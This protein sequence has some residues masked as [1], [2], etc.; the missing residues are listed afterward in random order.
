MQAT[1][2]HGF[3]DLLKPIGNSI[4][5]T[6]KQ[7]AEQQPALQILH[8]AAVIKRKE[9]IRL[10]LQVVIIF[11]LVDRTVFPA[12]GGPYTERTVAL[13]IK[14]S[15]TSSKRLIFEIG[16]SD[17]GLGLRF[18]SD[19]LVA[20]IASGS[21]RNTITLSNFASN[22]N[23]LSGQWNHVAVVY[24]VST[25]TLYL[26]GVSVASNNSLSF[27]SIGSS[28]NA[29]RLGDVSGTNSG[30]VFNDGSYS[31]YLGSMDNLYI[32]RSALGVADIN[33]LRTNTFAQ[34]VATTLAAPTPPAAPT[35]LTTEVLSTNAIKLTWNDNS[36]NETGFE[37]WRS[38][39]D[40][41]NNRKIATVDA[42]NTSSLTFTDST[43]F[44]N[45]TYYYKVRAIGL[46]GASAYTAEASGKTLN[47]KP[48]ITK[49]LDFTM[50]YGTTYVLPV[51]AVDVDG[52]VLTFS[53][54][55]LP[56]FATIENASNGNINIS[57]SPGYNQERC[58]YYICVC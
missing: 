26:N 8:S 30:V 31:D 42:G 53:T 58:I 48:V 21:T 36:S 14:P 28:S 34:S 54:F 43:L 9:L 32:I 20:G 37:I 12:T 55:N 18:N 51:K 2:R 33:T 3:Q 19:D 1:N 11:L 38:S 57:M 23:W 35:G 17:N 47:T 49:V 29:S 52:D 27:T 5:I 4:T 39:G 24:N 6:A 46:G 50:K 45:I 41:T 25:F 16:G 22:S 56:T 10:Y 7:M 15:S 40:K 44:A 13:W